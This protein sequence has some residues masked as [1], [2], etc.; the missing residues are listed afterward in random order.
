MSPLLRNSA[1]RNGDIIVMLKMLM[2]ENMTMNTT[3]STSWM[4]YGLI[5]LS[6]RR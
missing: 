2:N 6:M 3:A 5:I 1:S 4:V